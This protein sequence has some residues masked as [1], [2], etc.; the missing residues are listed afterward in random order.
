MVEVYIDEVWSRYVEVL[1]TIY[2]HAY[3]CNLII[4]CNMM[5]K[6]MTSFDESLKTTEPLPMPKV[7]PPTEIYDALKKLSLEESDLLRAYGKLIINER[8]FE[9]LKALPEEIKKPWLLSLP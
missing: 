2:V 3:F 6:M 1:N 5:G 8:L 9:A 4:M 7:T